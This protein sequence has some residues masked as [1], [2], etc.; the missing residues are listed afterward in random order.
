[1]D[2]KE[3]EDLI[4]QMIAATGESREFAEFFLDTFLQKFDVS[5]TAPGAKDIKKKSSPKSG[6]KRT[7]EYDEDH[8]PHFINRDVVKKYTLRFTLRDI[9][10]SI[11]RKVEVPSNI[12]LRHL[13]ELII[14]VMGWSGYHLN[15]FRVKEDFYEPFYQRD[16]DME[17]MDFMPLDH[18]NQE[19]YTIDDI[20]NEK[21][22]T[23]EF[24]YDFGDSWEH[25]IRLS[26]IDDYAEGEKKEIQFL[27]GKRA[28]PPEDCGGIWGYEDLCAIVAKKATHKRLSR[29]ERERLEWYSP[30]PEDGEYYD[31][32]NF[33]PSV[34]EIIVKRF[35]LY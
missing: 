34:G 19:D 30:A 3:R 15:H 1:M 24:E 17:A 32:E 4:R 7:P 20:L 5:D 6:S 22:K 14:S 11:W 27:G 29:D 33:D 25:V 2:S 10:P 8:Y 31:P 12:T 26:S 18:H 21:G 13:S 28:C 35:N 23:I 16:F 9:K